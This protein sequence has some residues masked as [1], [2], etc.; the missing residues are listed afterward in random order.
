MQ[1]TEHCHI[2][3]KIESNLFTL[4]HNLS[5]FL[6]FHSSC[7]QVAS[8]KGNLLSKVQSFGQNLVFPIACFPIAHVTFAMIS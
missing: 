1:M 8:S 7:K 6:L 5:A 3:Y 2:V 4:F